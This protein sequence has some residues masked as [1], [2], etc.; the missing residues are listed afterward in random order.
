MTRYSMRKMN[1]TSGNQSSDLLEPSLVLYYRAI[2][3]LKIIF[4]I[5]ININVFCYFSAAA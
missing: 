4:I 5:K 2:F 1:S 3:T